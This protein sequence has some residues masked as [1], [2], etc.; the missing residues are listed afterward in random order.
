MTNEGSI[1]SAANTACGRRGAQAHYASPAIWG[2]FALWHQMSTRRDVLVRLC[3]RA[4]RGA[5]GGSRGKQPQRLA[6]MRLTRAWWPIA[7][8]RNALEDT[9]DSASRRADDLA[10][11]RIQRGGG[12]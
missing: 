4:Y 5:R 9:A 12:R 7:R 10:T 2:E 11:V 8:W 3:E 1:R 6:R